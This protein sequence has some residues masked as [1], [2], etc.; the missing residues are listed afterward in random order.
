M[1][2]NHH[3][4]DRFSFARNASA[5][6]LF[7]GLALGRM[8]LIGRLPPCPPAQRAPPPWKALAARRASFFSYQGILLLESMGQQVGSSNILTTGLVVIEVD[9]LQETSKTCVH[10]Q[11]NFTPCEPPQRNGSQTSSHVYLHLRVSLI[12]TLSLLE[13]LCALWISAY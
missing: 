5:F 1:S 11:D 13:N 4:A 9:L 6:P 7:E 10:H 12:Y 2:S 8:P 3:T